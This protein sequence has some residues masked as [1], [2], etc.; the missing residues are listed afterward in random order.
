[1]HDA[2]ATLVKQLAVELGLA[3]LPIDEEYGTQLVID[4]T[5]VINIRLNTFSGAIVLFANIGS[6]D[7][8]RKTE[9]FRRAL[10]AN[11]FWRGTLG[12]TI[13]F[14]GEENQFLLARE[15]P[16][17]RLDV[18]ALLPVLEAFV[19]ATESLADALQRPSDEPSAGATMIEPFSRQYLQP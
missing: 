3:E 16:L 12:A 8:N 6:L 14:S 17:D 4:G 10:E 5:H 19:N 13:G 9:L 15:L 11:Y 1:M 18:A 2:F 7:E